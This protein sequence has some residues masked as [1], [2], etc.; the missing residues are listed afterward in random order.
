MGTSLFFEGERT[1][2]RAS[3]PLA[4]ATRAEREEFFGTR[5]PQGGFSCR[6]AAIHLLSRQ[7]TIEIDFASADAKVCDALRPFLQPVKLRP[8]VAE[9]GNGGAQRGDTGEV[10]AGGNDLLLSAALRKDCAQRVDDA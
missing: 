4:A 10:Q 8:P 1:P 9:D 2:L 3:L 5:T 6:F 7:K